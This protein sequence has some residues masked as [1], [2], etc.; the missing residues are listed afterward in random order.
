MKNRKRNANQPTGLDS[1]RRTLRMAAYFKA[2]LDNGD[3]ING[4]L[5]MRRF[6]LS[7]STTKRFIKL[8]KDEFDNNFTYSPTAGTY[9]RPHAPI[10]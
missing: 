5:L 10:L 1:V 3:I 7:R 4:P 8:Y 6:D 9:R 2:A